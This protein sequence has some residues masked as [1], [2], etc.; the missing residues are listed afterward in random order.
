[1]P[2][3]FSDLF[4][5]QYSDFEL[6]K[7]ETGLQF[8]IQDSEFRVYIPIVSTNTNSIELNCEFKHIRNNQRDDE[9]S[10]TYSTDLSGALYE[11]SHSVDL[12]S[13][14]NSIIE[15]AERSTEI[16]FK[17][18][19]LIVPL[20]SAGIAALVTVEGGPVA[21]AVAAAAVKES[22]EVLIKLEALVISYG[23]TAL[24]ALTS[25]LKEL[26]DDGGREYFP[27]VIAHAALRSHNALMG[28]IQDV[29][30]LTP[31]LAFDFSLFTV[32][33][34]DDNDHV[35]DVDTG[36][37]DGMAIEYDLDDY[38]FRS[39]KQDYTVGFVSSYIIVSGK[40]DRDRGHS[41]DD[42]IMLIAA[43]NSGKNLV[44]AQGTVVMHG[45]PTQSLGAIVS[46]EDGSIVQVVTED[47]IASLVT[48]N[49]NSI[50]KALEEQIED[51]LE[52]MEDYDDFSEG[53]MLLGKIAKYN[54]RW[55][56]D[57]ITSI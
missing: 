25:E 36:A 51:A 37:K 12:G 46:K 30:S 31:L 21:E 43:F 18:T 3:D 26:S 33:V 40:I 47:D 14:D 7:N 23:F 49:E 19:G 5:S 29:D 56:K 28:S 55:M 44:M 4:E 50:E 9:G 20:V 15:I 53:R 54:L 10:F 32:A 35:S 13:D 22:V 34:D 16:Y 1:M 11:Y 45:Q 39:W 27:L 52:N 41:T 6:V 17:I 38:T 48:I 57:S 42:H 8:T 2:T 24:G